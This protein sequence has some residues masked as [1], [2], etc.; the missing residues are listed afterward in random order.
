MERE[1]A[2]A[3]EGHPNQG[4][5]EAWDEKR[6]AL[7][8]AQEALIKEKIELEQQLRSLGEKIASLGERIKVLENAIDDTEH[9]PLRSAVLRQQME[10]EQEQ[11]P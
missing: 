7:E 5:L 1:S 2:P 10:R 3:F 8:V 6:R 9:N 4:L 11:N